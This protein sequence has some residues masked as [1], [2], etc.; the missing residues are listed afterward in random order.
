MAV[1]VTSMVLSALRQQAIL[2]S[3][4]ECCG[5][6]LGK[7]QR[8]DA[9]LPATNIHP[10]PDTHFEIDPQ[11]LIDAHR[12]A[13]GGGSQ[14][15]GYYHSHPDGPARPSATDR[16]MASGDGR[17]W[18]ITGE[19]GGTTFWRDTPDGFVSLSYVSRKDKCRAR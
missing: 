12:E 11:A 4:R 8:I 1:E 2:A 10:T 7:R 16:A 13:R 5:I 19:D 3:P 6:L 17:I 15:L 14:V 18:A 9:I